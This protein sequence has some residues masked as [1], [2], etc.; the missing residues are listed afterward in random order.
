MDAKDSP[1]LSVD[2]GRC[3]GAGMCALTAPAV[4]DQDDDGLVVLLAAAQATA[5]RQSVRTAAQVCPSGAITVREPGGSAV[6]ER[7]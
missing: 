1:R 5:H 6:T 4:F 7:H 3:Q 2:R